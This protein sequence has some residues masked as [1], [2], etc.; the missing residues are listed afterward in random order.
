MG[1]IGAGYDDAVIESFWSR[2]QIESLDRKKWTT[3]HGTRR[4]QTWNCSLT[5][6]D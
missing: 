5:V 1:T 3:R 6:A 4:Q 2:M